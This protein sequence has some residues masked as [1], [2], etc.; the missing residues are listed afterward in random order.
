M[1]AGVAAANPNGIKTLLAHSFSLFFIKRK[2][3][4]SNGARSLPRNPP[5]CT[6]LDSWVFFSF[7]LA[8][9]LFTLA[10]RSF[11]TCVLVDNNSCISW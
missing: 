10:L 4:Y 9:E 11:E 3:V 6:I 7:I 5:S 8:D 1:V 2:P